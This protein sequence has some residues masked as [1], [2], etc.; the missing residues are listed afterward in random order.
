[1]SYDFQTVTHGKWILTGEHSV[2]RHGAALVFPIIH[3][4]LTLTYQLTGDPLTISSPATQSTEIQ[5]LLSHAIHAALELLGKT[6]VVLRGH[7]SLTHNIPMGT[8]MGGSAALCVAVAR[9]FVY[10]KLVSTQQHLVFAQNLENIFH[11]KSSG[12]DIAGASSLAGVHFQNGVHRPVQQTWQPHWFLSFCGE[13]GLTAVCIQSVQELWDISEP[14]A[15]KIDAHMQESV[16][17]ALHALKLDKSNGLSL[18]AEA[19]EIAS[20]CF[21]QWGL[22]PAAL[23]NHMQQ[24]RNAGAI[25]VKP[26]GSGGGGYVLSLWASKP[27]LPSGNTCEL[28]DLTPRLNP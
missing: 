6:D 27:Q 21:L 4:N 8:G 7:L 26:T 2:L 11:G 10:L 3:K 23:A 17:L 22:V 14:L 16:A 19:I 20:S 12:V 25:A 1:M 28:L 9:W 5:E 18:L 15:K 13:K 24:L